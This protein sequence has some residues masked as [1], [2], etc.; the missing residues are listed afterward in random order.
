MEARSRYAPEHPDVRR[1]E[2]EIRALSRRAP[3]GGG[4][5]LQRELAS[6]QAALVALRQ[7]YSDNHPEVQVLRSVV[8]GLQQALRGDD[9]ATKVP[10]NPIYVQ[11]RGEL[12][13]VQLES[14]AARSRA[15]ELT[16]RIGDYQARLA[17]SPQVEREF[18]G[19]AREYETTR[20]KYTDVRAKQFEAEM[21]EAMEVDRKGERFELIE[22]P[23]P[24][25]EPVSPNRPLL[26]W[27]GALLAV[28]FGG[29]SAFV[30]EALD[31][32]VEGAD[33]LARLA[34]MAPIAVIPFIATSA[35]LAIER[36]RRWLSGAGLVLFLLAILVLVQ[37]LVAPLSTL[38]WGVV[39]RVGWF[40]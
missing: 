13:G 34:G 27:I 22:P 17:G 11:M 8:D 10:T 3:G 21:S 14:A 40:F 7:R 4:G 31:P 36:R 38:F 12:D 5:E 1:L 20:L 32:R 6:Q 26:L 39:A 24:P 18:Q 2:D 28:L 30:A 19:L 15:A 33:A 23:L 9:D 35:D 37:L 16:A 25:E 29:G